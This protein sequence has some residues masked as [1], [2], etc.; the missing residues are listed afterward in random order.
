MAQRKPY[1]GG[2]WKMNLHADEATALAKALGEN[3]ALTAKAD[4]AV[5]PAFPY[6]PL[7]ADALCAAGS[8]IKLGAQ[9][10]YHEPNGAFTGEVSLSMLK[11]VGVRTVLVGHSERRHVLGETDAVVNE[12]VLAALEADLEVVLCIGETLAQR[13]SGKTDAINKG[14]LALGFAGVTAEQMSKVTIAYE[15]VWAIGTGKTATP[16]DAQAAHAEIR[17]FLSNLCG[18]EVANAVRIQYGG[19]CKP[20]N[21]AELFALKDVDGGLIGGAS[22]KS[23]DFTQII[24]AAK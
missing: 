13:E 10:F 11:D 1:V 19:S 3:K 15:P 17:C 20:G 6:L 4:V 5:F 2:N 18:D 22:L 24:E 14:Q 12:K 23:D 8:E 16:D 9:D 21:A 7:V